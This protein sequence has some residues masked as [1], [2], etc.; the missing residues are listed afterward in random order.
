MSGP[1]A[2]KLAFALRRAFRENRTVMYSDRGL[3]RRYVDPHIQTTT[4]LGAL[5]TVWKWTGDREVAEILAPSFC[6]RV[7]TTTL[8]ISQLVAEF[9]QEAK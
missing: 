8:P 5:V 6:Q 3:T 1:N 7:L 4:G 2:V 9:L